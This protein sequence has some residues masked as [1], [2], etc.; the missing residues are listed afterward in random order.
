[1]RRLSLVRGPVRLSLLRA[2]RIAPYVLL[3]IDSVSFFL[4]E[5]DIYRE[6]YLV[7]LSMAG[8]SVLWVIFTSM[9]LALLKTCLYTWVCM[10]SLLMFNVLSLFPVNDLYYTNFMSIIIFTG[11]SMSSILLIRKWIRSQYVTL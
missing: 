3:W 11:M 7:I 9:M 6:L 2:I 8:H 10:V 4:Y 5:L 1:M